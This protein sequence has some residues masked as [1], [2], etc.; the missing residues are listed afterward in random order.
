[1]LRIQKAL[2]T[3]LF[4]LAANTGWAATI[5]SATLT[6]SQ[7]NPPTNPTTSTGASRP[8]PFGTATFILND[9]MSALTF[10]ATI[11]NIDFTGSQTP[12]ANDNLVAAHI[13]AGSAVTPTTNGPVVWGFFGMPFNDTNSP[14]PGN[15]CTPFTTGVGGTCAGTWDSAEGNGAGVNLAAELPFILSG[16]SYINFHTVQ[17]GGG[18]IRGNIQVVP[19]PTTLTLFGLGAIGLAALRRHMRS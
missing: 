4:A 10:S 12:D 14:T 15:D 13:H 19:E 17:N 6:T 1:M 5:L 9:A 2:L 18:E 3:G 8:T 11:F 16:K 7:E